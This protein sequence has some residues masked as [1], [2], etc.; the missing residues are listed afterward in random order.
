VVCSE[1][2][3]LHC[4]VKQRPEVIELRLF[5][6][7]HVNR[8]DLMDRFGVSVNQA[9]TDLNRCIGSASDNMVYDKSARSYVRGQ[10]FAPHFLKPD[11][12]RYLTQ[13]WTVDDGL[14]DIVDA[15]IAEFPAFD[16]A[17]TPVRGIATEP[18]RTVIGAIKKGEAIEVLYLSL[19]RP[20][21]IWRWI[22]P[23]AIAFDGFR[24]HA[25]AWCEIH[26]MFQD[27]VLSRIRKVRNCRSRSAEPDADSDWS[28]KIALRIAPY[29]ELS[30]GQ[31]AVVAPVYGMEDGSATF[32]AR[33]ALLYEALKRLG[34]DTDPAARRP[35]DQQIVLVGQEAVS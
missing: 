19:P 31:K 2:S 32:R 22:A 6:K 18:L 27:F 20:E 7:G 34:L 12:S 5:W 10:G 13:L 28:T 21:A 17:P 14:L 8:S 1:T 25:R 23:H 35:H 29:P 26:S 33:K 15:W 24:W 30:N 9:C 3:E 11:A 16:A 4:V